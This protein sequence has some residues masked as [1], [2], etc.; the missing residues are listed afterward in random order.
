MLQLDAGLSI[1]HFLFV[2]ILVGALSAEAFLLRLPMT[3]PLAR[4]LLRADLFYGIS[5]AGLVAAGFSRAIWGAKG[6]HYYTAEPFF[7]AKIATFSVI[8]L[9]SI[10]PTMTYVRWTRAYAKDSAH[11]VPEPE[12]KRARRLVMLEVH[13]LALVIVFAALMARGIGGA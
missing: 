2:F 11:A 9:I 7:W 10:W 1:L 3:L 8:G 5:A 13:A 12:I 4:L 6:W